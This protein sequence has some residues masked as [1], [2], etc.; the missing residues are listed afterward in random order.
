M[1]VCVCVAF[2]PHWDH[3]SILTHL[4]NFGWPTLRSKGMPEEE[5]EEEEEGIASLAR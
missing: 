3:S 4:P 1:C 5:V 2:H